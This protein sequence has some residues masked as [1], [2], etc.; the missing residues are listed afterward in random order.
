MV[1]ELVDDLYKRAKHDGNLSSE[2]LGDYSYSMADAQTLE[3]GYATRLRKWIE[4]PVGG[5]G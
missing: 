1:A 2:S 4:I 5:I 3:E